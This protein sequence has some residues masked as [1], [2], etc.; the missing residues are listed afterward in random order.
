MHLLASFQSMSAG[1]L[2][3]RLGVGIIFFVHGRQKLAMWKAQPSAQMSAGMLN[4]LKFLSVAEPLGSL[5]VVAGFFTQPAAAGLAC[6]MVGAIYLKIT[7][8]QKKFTG[9]GGWEFE[10]ILLCAALALVFLGGG[11]FALDRAWYAI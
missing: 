11:S 6:I 1:L 7:A 9:E 10:F 8:W 5:A 2:I 3:L 4:L